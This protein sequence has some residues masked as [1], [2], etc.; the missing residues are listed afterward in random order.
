VPIADAAQVAGH[1][2]AFAGRPAALEPLAARGSTVY[3]TEAP[4]AKPRARVPLQ[5]VDIE[6]ERRDFRDGFA[7]RIARS[8]ADV[9]PAVITKW[10]PDVIVCDETDFGSMIVAERLRLPYVTVLVTAA[11]TFAEPELITSTLD[12]VRAEHGLAPDP[13]LDMVSGHLVLAPF[14]PGYR[15]P[16]SPLPASAV[17][18]RPHEAHRDETGGTPLVYFTLGTEFNVESGDLFS[19]ALAGLAGLP[20]EVVVTVGRDRDP[21]ELGPQPAHVRVER[22][23]PQAELLQRASVVVSHAGSGSVLGALAHGVP[24]VLLPMGADQPYNAARC[25]ELGV[26]RTLDVI[27]ATPD[28]VRAAAATVLSDP[29]YAAATMRW[30]DEFAALPGPEHA[31]V[32]LEQLET[33]G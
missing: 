1:D 11:R 22:F 6:R 9:L 5:E 7:D 31:V 12:S 18:F 2:V 17:A 3:A 25:E 26:A 28:D 15:D 19:R 14:P 13:D 4:R 21:A 24:M 32:L 20:V 29:S 23:V 30:R 10:R 16:L 8:K 27:R 33:S